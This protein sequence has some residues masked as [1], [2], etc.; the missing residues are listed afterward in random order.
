MQAPSA[1]NRTGLAE[2][3]GCLTALDNACRKPNNGGRRRLELG[4]RGSEDSARTNQAAPLG[5][6]H[7]S[8]EQQNGPPAGVSRDEPHCETS[9]SEDC[10][11][12]AGH[13]D[14]DAPDPPETPSEMNRGL[15]GENSLGRGEASRIGE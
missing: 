15:P 12:E 9:E 11:Q 14:E 1:G 3:W 13:A 2:E 10:R 4:S 8:S 6:R 7:S 5:R